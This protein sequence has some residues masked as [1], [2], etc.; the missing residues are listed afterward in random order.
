MSKQKN[1]QKISE[2]IKK[3]KIL[4][5]YGLIKQ[6][7]RKKPTPQQ[8][9][10]ITRQWNK[11]SDLLSGD[12]AVKKL[13]K[14]Q[15]KKY[16]TN[17]YKE[18]N[19]HI[20]VDKRKFSRVYFGK[21]KITFSKKGKK[22]TEL[23]VDNSKFIKT[24]EANIKKYENKKNIVVM[25]TTGNGRVLEK[26]AATIQD[27]DKYLKHVFGQQLQLH[28]KEKMKNLSPSKRAEYKKKILKGNEEIL[29]KIS[30]IE[31]TRKPTTRKKGSKKNA[32]KKQKSRRI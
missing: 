15:L 12:Y 6:D 7:L 11:Y 10:A 32:N 13:Q 27:F 23:L 4:K 30:I 29:N 21:D 16:K 24:M 5:K 22:E 3:R 20:F 26:R 17:G 18:I 1:K 8:K 28:H 14:E 2:N 19:G 9:A 31:V 25:Y